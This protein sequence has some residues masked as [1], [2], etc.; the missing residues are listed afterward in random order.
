ME[1]TWQMAL[2]LGLRWL[3]LLGGILW[4][5]LAFYMNFVH[6]AYLPVLDPQARRTAMLGLIPRI[7]VFMGAGALL[8]V[9]SGLALGA[10]APRHPFPPFDWLSFGIILGFL[11]FFVGFL[12]ILPCTLIAMKAFRTGTPAPAWAMRILPLSSK[13]NA[14][15]SVPMIFAMLAGAGH[16]SGPL[17]PWVF[18]VCVLGW[19]LVWLLFLVSRKVMVEV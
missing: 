9:A 7:L 1:M 6:M 4:V 17:I 11:M 18:G 15:L 8:S 14:Y 12:I 13:L 5:G 3:H 16:F 2:T 19:T 10:L